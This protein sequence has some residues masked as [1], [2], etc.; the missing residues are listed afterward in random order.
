MRLRTIAKIIGLLL[1]ALIVA[2][3]AFVLNLDPNDHKDRISAMVA[4]KTGRTLSFGGPIDLDIGATTTLV[5]RDVSFS[6]TDW[7]SRPE[8][9]TVGLLEVDIRLFPLIVGDI[10]IEQI[11]L[12]DADVVIETDSEGRSNTEFVSEDAASGRD[13]DSDGGMDIAVG[14]VRIENV[15]VSIID[16]AA[17]QTIVA[18]LDRAIAAS[19]APG[20]PLDVD[21]DGDITLD[22][23]IARIV[24]DGQM[25]SSKAILSGNQP[26]P[27]NLTG[28]VLGYDVEIDG[29]VRQP[30]NPDGFDVS[31]SVLGDGLKAIQPF[32]S[33]QLPQLGPVEISA[34]VTGAA[35]API[36]EDIRISAA[37]TVITGEAE[38]GPGDSASYNL[39]ATLDGQNL[40]LVSPYAG[41]PLESLGPLTGSINIVGDMDALRLE[42]NAVTVDRSKLSGSVTAGLQQSPPS[43][44]YD[45]TLTVDGQT[46]DIV[47]PFVGTELPALGPITGTIRAV[48]NQTKARIE[49]TD[50]RADRSTLGGQITASNLDQ[51][52]SIEYDVTL[53]ADA[54]SL[55]ILRPYV[56]GDVAELGQINGGVQAIGSLDKARLTLDDILIDN[57]QVSGRADIDRSG[58]TIK[59]DYDVTLVATD[60]SL[61]ILRPF[62]GVD[63]PAVGPVDLTAS[64]QGNAQ[65]ARFENFTLRFEDSQLSGSGQVDLGGEN[66]V[67]SAALSS[68]KF[69]LT[70]FFPDTTEVERPKLITKEEAAREAE[71]QNGGPVFPTDPLPF[72][73]INTAKADVSLQIGEFVT[74]YGTYR[75]VD[76]RLV[77]A[78]GSAT[79]RPLSATYADSP[80]SGNLSVDT[81]GGTPL[82]AVSL[83]GSKIAIGQVAQDFANL[84]VLQGT[85]SLNIAVNGSGRSVA[86]IMGSLNGHARILMGEGR[87]RNEGLG[88]VSGVFSS[89]G[90]I[91][92]RKEWVIVECLANHFQ[93][94]NGIAEAKVGILDTEV[95]SLTASGN[96]NLQTERYDLKVK[97]LPRGL[98]ISLAVPVNVTGPLNDPAFSP[99][100]IG[101]LT[102]LGS[103][104]G[105]VLFPP[106]ALIG[107]TEMGGNNHPCV[108]FAKES[109]GDSSATPVNPL[110]KGSSG[111]VLGAP[112]R[113][114][115]GVGK[116]L[117]GVL[118]N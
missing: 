5:V 16:A 68:T 97:P 20:A 103:I 67:V 14:Q 15:K 71:S 2:A 3:V 35:E 85:G 43:V 78:D 94:E 34:H 51:T 72:D 114:L 42:P 10:D 18:K 104:F 53:R 11:A 64:L 9:A 59:A 89:I 96:I 116:G 48:G 46:L 19:A 98:D 73:L 87:M 22:Q 24:L 100:A 29:G 26:V 21:V 70:R 56:G 58:E 12:K 30:E 31:I 8:M 93:I 79:V 54:Q 47:E 95:I 76:V 44:D 1:V 117:K 118:G 110:E 50:V 61:D 6:N 84:D 65:Q 115:D 23:N 113:V 88:Y 81:A 111:G 55:E 69:D 74:P 106:V 62:L 57:S 60:Q 63:L 27:I 109:A 105:S 32:V 41:L 82:V 112:G 66:P 83:S 49:V 38:F 101:S 77:A 92:G 80:I 86:D 108:E 28:T 40:G 4:E 99:D 102:K 90:E 75:D 91:L 33:T 37:R 17:N 45:M 36:V 107:L 13:D 7:A 52:P 39:K 25:G